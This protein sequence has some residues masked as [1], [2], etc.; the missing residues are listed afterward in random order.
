QLFLRVLGVFGFRIVG[1]NQLIGGNGVGRKLLVARDVL[2]L[3]E[4]GIALEVKDIGGV[5]A[6]G[7][8]RHIAVGRQDRLGQLA[9]AIIGIDLHQLG[10]FQQGIARMLAVELLQRLD[11][12]GV[13][14]PVHVVERFLVKRGGRDDRRSEK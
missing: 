1:N 7:I 14:L 12:G 8:E 5:L 6:I 9:A 4:I 11:R 13:I 10:L 3:G 2:D